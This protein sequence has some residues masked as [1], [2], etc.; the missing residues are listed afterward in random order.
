LGAPSGSPYIGARSDAAGD[1]APS[2][3]LG[4][5]VV[6]PAPSA[7][8]GSV[9]ALRRSSLI[10][11]PSFHLAY[12]SLRCVGGLVRRYPAEQRVSRAATGSPETQALSGGGCQVA[13]T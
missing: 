8:G 4:A 12:R 11:T 9:W 5:V 7:A 1:A 3:R 13:D 2:P 6:V 10:A